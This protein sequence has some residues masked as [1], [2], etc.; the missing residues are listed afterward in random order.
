MSSKLEAYSKQ[1]ISL[2]SAEEYKMSACKDLICDLKI[3]CVY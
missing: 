2:R 1:T 3:L